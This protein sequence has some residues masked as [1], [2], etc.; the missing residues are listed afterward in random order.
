MSLPA[1]LRE[2]WFEDLPRHCCLAESLGGKVP[3]EMEAS[4]G[5]HYDHETDR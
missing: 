2:Q 1:F 3:V 4:S 5:M